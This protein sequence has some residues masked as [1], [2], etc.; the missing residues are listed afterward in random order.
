MIKLLKI[1]KIL[2]NVLKAESF[3]KSSNIFILKFYWKK[4]KSLWNMNNKMF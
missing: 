3:I 1:I 2:T 4:K